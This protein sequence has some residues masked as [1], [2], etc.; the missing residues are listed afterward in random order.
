MKKT[1]RWILIALGILALLYIARPRVQYF[2][3]DNAGNP[4]PG[5]E[6]SQSSKA[7]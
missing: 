2:E 3:T 1:I 4:I 7:K 5:T 6:S